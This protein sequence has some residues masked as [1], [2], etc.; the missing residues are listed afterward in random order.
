MIEDVSSQGPKLTWPQ[1][2][3]LSP[4]MRQQW[5]KMVSTRTSKLMGAVEARKDEDVLPVLEAYIKGQRIHKVYVDGGAQVCV[6]TEKMMHHLG[7]EVQGKSEFKAKMT[8]NVSVKCVGVCRGVKITVCGIKVAVDMYVI[9]AKGEGYPIILGRPWLIAMNARQDWEKGTLVLKPP[10]KKSGEAIL[11]NMRKGKQECLEVETSEEELST[12]DSSSASD[13]ASQSSSEYDSSLDVCGVILKEP[14]NDEGECSK[15][16]LKE[17][18]V[19]QEPQ[20]SSC[21]VQDAPNLESR[22]E[23]L[24]PY[25]CG[26]LAQRNVL[27]HDLCDGISSTHT[28]SPHL[29]E[30]IVSSEKSVLALVPNERQI[31]DQF[32]FQFVEDLEMGDCLQWLGVSKR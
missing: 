30:E 8:N 18:E 29:C 13:S 11:Y 26:E 19:W 27:L 7:M 10:G 15:S 31:V 20:A 5:S 16:E 25:E 24:L 21:F 22:G 12:S 28:L 1:L 17:E 9:P 23:G 3:H 32:V 14:N 4:K 2:L 6:M